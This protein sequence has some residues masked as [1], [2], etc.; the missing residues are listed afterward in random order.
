MNDEWKFADKYVK[1]NNVTH[2]TKCS[3]TNFMV[4]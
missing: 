2:L 4:Q 1:I 3:Q